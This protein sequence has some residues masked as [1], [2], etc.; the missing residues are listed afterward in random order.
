MPATSNKFQPCI[1]SRKVGKQDS[2]VPPS[3]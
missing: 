3:A 2:S 1:Y